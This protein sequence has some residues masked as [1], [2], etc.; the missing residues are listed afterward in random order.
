MQLLPTVATVASKT[1]RDRDRSLDLIRIVSLLVVV[2]GHGVMLLVSVDSDG[3]H[4]GNL[5]TNSPVLQALTWVLQVLPLFFFAGAA[6]SAMGYKPEANWGGWLLRRAQRLYRPVFYYVAAWAVTLVVLQQFVAADVRRQIAGLSIQLLWFI[7]VYVIVLAFVPA[8]TRMTRGR[9]LVMVVGV[10]YVGAAAVDWTRLHDGPSTLSYLNILVWLIPAALG[11]GYARG[12][13]T[14]AAAAA[15]AGALFL[16][17]V[18]LVAVGPYELSL[19]TVEG[20]RLSNMTPP[21]LVLAG[22]AV[23]LSCLFI[24]IAPWCDRLARNARVWWLVAIGNG[25]AMTLYLWHMPALLLV[26]AVSHLLGYDRADPGQPGFAVLLVAQV[27]ALYAVTAVLFIAL[28]RLE[29][30]PLPWWDEAVTGNSALTGFAVVTAGVANLLAAKWGLVGPG[31]WFTILAL[32]A[33]VVA[34]VVDK[35]SHEEKY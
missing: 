20:Q 35:D 2:T 29:N 12:L 23:V 16:V 26:T 13:V 34:R 30:R 4:F 31:I 19:V 18:L 32:C 21:S 6:S 22:H 8:L 3:L 15:L 28:Q 5:L 7:G 11:V 33:L 1:P 14:R 24:A 17:D 27:L 10:V 9:H 25:G